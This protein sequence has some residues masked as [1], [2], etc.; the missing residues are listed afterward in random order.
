ME[1]TNEKKISFQKYFLVLLFTL[2][3][4]GSGFFLSDYVTKKRIAQLNDL[5]QNLRTD[6]LS[7]ETQFSILNQAPCANL[8]ESTLTNELYDISQKLMS[9]GSSLGENDEQFLELKKY[10]SILEIKHWLLLQRAADEC[11]LP[12]AFIIYFY[13]DG[14]NCPQ[15]EDQGYILTYFREKYPFLR[16]Y[17]FDYDLELAALKTLKSVFRLKD[18]T[19]IMVINNDAYYGYKSKEELE[20]ILEKYVKLETLEE[21]ETATSTSATSSKKSSR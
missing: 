8:N 6:I 9:V 3:I 21:K 2:L 17:S 18:G 16:I 10:Y 20:T 15:C 12:L 5:Q 11:K 4:F 19:P 7:L 14:K 13:E 1:I